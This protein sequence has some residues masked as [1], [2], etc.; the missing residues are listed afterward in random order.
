[1][2]LKLFLDS[3]ELRVWQKWNKLGIFHG[4]TTNPTLLNKAGWASN[5]E[6]LEKITN[7]V[8]FLGYKS[9]HLQAWG[10]TTKEIIECAEKIFSI[11]T[12]ITKIF[13]KIPI[14]KSGTEAAM[15]LIKEDIPITFTACYDARQ[16]LIAESLG[17]KYIAP[18][19]GRMNDS[20][21][22]GYKEIVLMQEILKNTNSKCEL[23][24]ASI[25][26]T[27]EVINLASKGIN[28]FTLNSNI[29]DSF[30]EV[31]QTILDSLSFEKD[32]SLTT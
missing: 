5:Q 1:M 2:A 30:Y 8:D 12:K 26:D 10:K 6:T 15:H 16:I 27:R 24:V 9:I 21:I 31:N 3:A 23:L 28:T 17:A 4:I 32:T 19:L 20:G 14:T 13:I 7:Q 25:R 22:D 11:E 18:Y 29:S